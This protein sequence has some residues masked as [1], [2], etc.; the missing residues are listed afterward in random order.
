MFKFFKPRRIASGLLAGFCLLTL[1]SCASVDPQVYQQQRPALDIRQYFNG[2]VEAWGVFTDRS[3]EVKKRFTVNMRCTWQTING[4]ETGTLDEDFTYADG[5][6]QKRV[7]TLRKV[8]EHRYIGT[9]A[10]VVGEA[11]GIESGNALHWQYTLALP[12]DG[13]V[14]HVQF[15]DWMFLMDDKVML[16]RASMS[17][18]GIHLGDVTL[19]F[20][21]R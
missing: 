1:Q 6:K 15:S 14:Y 19:S 5:T 11:I 10:D 3:G 7:W 18:F 8:A 9:A 20:T 4:V 12:V 13:S 2:T 17:K 21:K 16:N